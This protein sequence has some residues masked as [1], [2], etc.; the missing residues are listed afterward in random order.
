MK[1]IVSSLSFY[2]PVCEA[3]ECSNTIDWYCCCGGGNNE[4]LYGVG[5]YETFAAYYGY[6]RR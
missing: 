3:S 6:P 5:H 1:D 4:H 2:L